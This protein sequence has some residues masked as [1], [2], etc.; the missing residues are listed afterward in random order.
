MDHQVFF[1]AG[2]LLELAKS[3][4]EQFGF[5]KQL[6]FS[7]VISFGVV[8]FA[9]HRW[10]YKPILKVLEER[11]ERIAEGL[12]NA[13]KIKAELANAQAKAQE[14]LTQA[15][16][17]GNK[18]IEEARVSAA[19]VLE[20]ES[21]KAIATANDIIAKARQASEAELVRMKGELRKEVGRLVVA[22]SAKVTGNILTAEQQTRLAEDTNKQLATN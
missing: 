8:C 17:Q 7:Q 11:R 9:L 12:A 22:T 21:Q 14:I 19:K 18:M 6:F 20:T 2:N 1:A 3:T 5:Q 16:A 10:A 13:E 4:G 15:G